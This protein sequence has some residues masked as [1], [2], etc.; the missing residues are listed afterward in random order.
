MSIDKVDRAEL[1]DDAILA[2]SVPFE[3]VDQKIEVASVFK[4]EVLN[5]EPGSYE[6]VFQT[7]KTGL[8]PWVHLQ[9]IPHKIDEAKILKGAEH[10]K[11]GKTLLMNGEPA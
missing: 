2:I 7:G 10:L 3:L 9:F 6:L 11:P 4:G 8:S 5:F 1:R